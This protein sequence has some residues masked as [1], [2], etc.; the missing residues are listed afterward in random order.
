MNTA[1]LTQLKN[2]YSVAVNK[3]VARINN[4]SYIF[5]K[6]FIIIFIA[7]GLVLTFYFFGLVIFGHDLKIEVRAVFGICLLLS[8]SHSVILGFIYAILFSYTND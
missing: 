4:T 6:F 3:D 1:L 5:L 7:F 2:K 8:L